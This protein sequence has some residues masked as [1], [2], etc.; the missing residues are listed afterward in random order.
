MSR[1][2]RGGPTGFARPENALKRAD[3]LENV[4][5]QHAALQALH[6]IICSKKHRTWSKTYESIMFKHIDLCVEMKKRNHAKE[7]LM[8]YRNMCHQVNINS[9]EEV[10]KYFLK[11]ASDKAEEAQNKAASITL[12]VE[13]LDEEASP[14]DLMLSY[15]SGEKSK[16]RTD[17]EL[18]TPWFRFLWESYR[19]VLEILRTNPKL[20]G[21]YAMTARKAF[22]FCLQYKRT[23]EFKRLC[24]IL[25]QHLTQ[26]SN[27]V[28]ENRE[29]QPETLQ[30]HLEARFEQLQVAC[31]LELWA[32]AFRSVEDIQALIVLNNKKMPKQSIMAGYYA[33]LTQIF[34]VSDNHLYHAY[35][36]LKLFGFSKSYN[37][38][39]TPTDLQAMAT[40]V[41]LATLSILPYDRTEAGITA[42]QEKERVIRMT[43]IL[44]FPVDSKRDYRQLLTR[45]GLLSSVSSANI[46][47]LVPQEVRAIH[48]LITSDFNPLELCTKLA[49]LF[50]RLAEISTPLSP[51][52]PIKDVALA[53]YTAS[54]KQVAVLR[55]LKQMSEVYS[56]VRISSLAELVPFATFNE[57]EAIIVDAVKFDYLQ[58]HIDHRNGTLQFGNL[59][60]ES[61]AVQSHLSLLAQRLSRA[62]TLLAP[63]APEHAQAKKAAAIQAGLDAAVGEHQRALA[64]KVI[65]E[66]R[67]EEA[68]KQ[69]LE[70]EKE[71]EMRKR[72]A[73][74]EVEVAEEKRRREEMLRREKERIEKEL[75]ERDLEEAKALLESSRKKGLGLKPGKEGEKLSK[76]AM[77]QEVMSER[78][79][80]QQELERKLVKMGRQLDHL[81]RAKR[82][83]EVPFIL[84]AYEVRQTEDKANHEESQRAST[85]AH[86]AAW[87]TDIV[88]KQR[89]VAMQD[90]KAAFQVVIME[91]RE[92]EFKALQKEKERRLEELRYRRTQEREVLRQKAFVQRC[93][94]QVNERVKVLEEIKAAAELERKKAEEAERQ[95]RQ[96]EA[97]AQ[98]R[99]RDEEI[100]LK[101]AED[102]A[103]FMAQA[104]SR[105]AATPASTTGSSGG[106]SGYVPPSRR[107]AADADSSSSAAAP[108]AAAA[109][110]PRAPEGDR[111]SRSTP[112]AAP[113]AAAPRDTPAPGAA[114]AAERPAAA[115]PAAAAAATPAPAAAAGGRFVPSFRR[116]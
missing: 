92:G 83:E 47:G 84:A 56:T 51:A 18:V 14:E 26:L 78:A 66:G 100:E 16:D 76:K 67:K 48:E 45:G 71:A 39:L 81:E 106:G 75:E 22:S 95:K 80:E 97:M 57:V 87:D 82:E 25:R 15:V 64:R 19:S 104:P 43:H 2:F 30:M 114:A 42:E 115:A 53:S 59:R 54:L 55:L 90:E 13:D 88:E 17:R 63:A 86:L 12:D 21:L 111:W 28:R 33:R 68:E 77:M 60:L 94:D 108:A 3:E 93:R 73:A 99:A 20:E 7:A 62:V 50:Q 41:L 102:R 109:A 44:G 96:D 23:A 36:W 65:I 89:L 40:S 105:P 98:Q 9:L 107:G 52:A 91:R 85:A 72:I 31:D 11:K 6:E 61:Q 58:V 29:S 34:A 46:M 27:R 32:E 116:K 35:A 113:V 79:K 24:D 112:A 49:P 1:P 74:R 38:S 10:I 8:Q 4:G 70:A 37:R 5:Q 101:R 110:A 69:L 103:A